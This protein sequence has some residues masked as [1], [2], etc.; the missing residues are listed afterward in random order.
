MLAGSQGQQREKISIVGAL[1]EKDLGARYE[2][3]EASGTGKLNESKAISMLIDDLRNKNNSIREKAAEIL[4]KYGTNQSAEALIQALKDNDSRVVANAQ[5]SLLTM[6]AL[7]VGPL[8]M[9]LKAENSTIKANAVQVLGR[10]GDARAIGPLNELA[11]RSNNSAVQ[12]KVAYA[13]RK[14]HHKKKGTS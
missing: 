12:T 9:A 2:A 11:M 5:D 7:S 10:I 3:V 6:G 14:L 13:L 1:N 8:T 4:G